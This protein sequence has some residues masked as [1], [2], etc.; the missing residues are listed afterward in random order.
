VKRAPLLLLGLAV[1]ASGAWL[2]ATDSHLTFIADDW[3]LLVARQGT[4]LDYF[5]HPFH[6]NVLVGPAILYRLLLATV[7]MGSATPFFVVSISAFLASAVLLF[8]YL[9]PRLGEWGALVATV[10]VL[11]LGAAFEDLMFAFQIGYF[12]SVAAGLGALVAL[13]RED[14]RGDRAACV[15]LVVSL[16][17]SSVGLAF[18]CGALA[19]LALGRRPRLRRAYVALAPVAL[20]GLW[21]LGWGRH[22]ES[23]VTLHNLLI[24]PRFAFDS[25]AA[26]LTS[27]AGLATGDGSEPSQPHLI[28][29]QL[30]LVALIG[31]V[32]WRVHRE[33]RLSRGMAIA[34]ALGLGLWVL[35]ALNRD[36]QRLP[37]SSRYQYPSAVALLLIAGEA[38][39]GLRAPA[40]W[41]GPALAGAAALA[42]LALWGGISLLHREYVE[43]WRPVSDGLRN[44]LGVI[45]IA[46]K[47]ADPGFPIAFAPSPVL[48]ASEYLRAVADYGSPGYTEAQLLARPPG[49]RAAADLTLAQAEGLRLTA[50]GTAADSC[51]VLRASAAGAAGPA[52]GPGA[53]TIANR[54]GAPVEVLL[55]RFAAD[56]SVDLGPLPA[57]ER[58]LLAIPRDSSPRPWRFFLRGAGPVRLCA[59]SAGG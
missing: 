35:T 40:R 25:A 28:W 37:T 45:D 21:W 49:D 55:A 19:D 33:G 2:L 32:C 34:L 11:F 46:G 26:G 57:G 14:D 27:L 18:A 10:L 53:H 52:L 47:R 29:G 5:L 4:G 42:A 30:L 43:R 44:T 51:R 3:Q 8:A 59:A 13:D 41:R 22:G 38:L 9:L 24:A 15:L 39:R 20:Y 58:T 56:P 23:H 12:A 36:S 17:F 48:P 7:G 50:S 6:G 31:L 1:A 16:A 54:S